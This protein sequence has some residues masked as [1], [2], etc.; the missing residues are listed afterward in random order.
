[1]AVA[2]QRTDAYK[3]LGAPKTEAASESGKGGIP[4]RIGN[5]RGL[6]TAPNGD[7]QLLQPF[8]DA[9]DAIGGLRRRMQKETTENLTSY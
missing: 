1:V 5:G 9:A 7:I 4:G 6:F 3:T 2:L 8:S